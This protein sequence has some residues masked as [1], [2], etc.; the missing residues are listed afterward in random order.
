MSENIRNL[1]DYDITI[2]NVHAYLF[3]G[4][5]ATAR[6][7]EY[8]RSNL[9]SKCVILKASGMLDNINQMKDYAGNLIYF[10]EGDASKFFVKKYPELVMLFSTGSQ[11]EQIID[12]WVCTCY[13]RRILYFI[14]KNNVQLL[15]DVL[16]DCK[17]DTSVCYDKTWPLVDCVIENSPEAPDHDT[18]VVVSRQ[19]IR[20][21]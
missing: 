8:V 13:E 7:K 19:V 12:E 20:E 4:E 17:F 3:H 1:L 11:L 15:V 6:I 5:D 9:E 21:N 14:D 2:N 16:R 18:F 10:E